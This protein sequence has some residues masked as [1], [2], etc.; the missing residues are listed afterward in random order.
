[1]P[2]SDKGFDKILYDSLPE[3]Y[4]TSDRD[5]PI[6]PYPLKRFLQ[7]TSVGLSKAE[8]E[9][10]ELAMMYDIDQTASKFLIPLGKTLGFTFPKGSTEDEVRKLLDNIP[11]LYSLKG[12]I[13][14]FDLLARIIF[15]S[16]AKTN[17]KWVYEGEKVFVNILVELGDNAVIDIEGKRKRFIELAESFRPV[18][19]G[20][21]WVLTVFY[22][23]EFY[24]KVTVDTFDILLIDDNLTF[25]L[26]N[27]STLNNSRLNTEFI[28]PF[29]VPRGEVFVPKVTTITTK[30]TVS[31]LTVELTV[32]EAE[33]IISEDVV[34]SADTEKSI[35]KTTE[36]RYDKIADISRMLNHGL[37]GSTLVLNEVPTITIIS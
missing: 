1:M 19:V 5:I 36:E 18:N 17:A 34:V 30:D 11:E 29:P 27:L 23:D 22:D 33:E 20:V 3:I 21:E 26:D 9:I 37:L 28:L 24:N 6:N 14:V 8:K 25:P 10:D 32:A 31:D 2:V 4:R 7:V 15:H 35:V 13:R 12:N 16:D